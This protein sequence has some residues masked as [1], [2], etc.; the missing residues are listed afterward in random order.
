MFEIRPRSSIQAQD[1]R[2]NTPIFVSRIYNT[3]VQDPQYHCTP[4]VVQEYAYKKIYIWMRTS[5][6][7]HNLVK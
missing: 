5:E 2:V 7:D 1:R 3:Q 4:Q 6:E